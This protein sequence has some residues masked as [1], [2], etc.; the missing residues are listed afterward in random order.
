[1][2]KNFFLIFL[3]LIIIILSVQFLFQLKNQ[4]NVNVKVDPYKDESHFNKKKYLVECKLFNE[5]IDRKK[6]DNERQCYYSCSEEDNVRV[7]TSIGF[8]CQPFI[9]E[10]R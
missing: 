6:I 7:D 2:R 1:M 3:L 4:L 8:P 10:E 9:L 5:I